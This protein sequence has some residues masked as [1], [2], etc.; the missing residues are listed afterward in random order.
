ML[1]VLNPESESNRARKILQGLPTPTPVLLSSQNGHTGLS[2]FHGLGK[3]ATPELSC[4]RLSVPW[5]KWESSHPYFQSRV[6]LT[7]VSILIKRDRPCKASS[8]LYSSLHPHRS[9][10]LL[11]WE[12]IRLWCRGL[13]SPMDVLAHALHTLPLL[14]V[15]PRAKRHSLS[16]RGAYIERRWM[17]KCRN[18][19]TGFLGLLHRMPKSLGAWIAEIN[20]LRAPEMTRVKLPGGRAMVW[21]CNVWTLDSQMG[22]L[23]CGDDGTLWNRLDIVPRRLT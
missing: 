21:V 4:P 18:C 23:I 6:M 7:C 5:W 16:P 13:L 19:G 22:V 17:V 9:Y 2:S 15:E 10:V 20:P 8:F 3:W 1:V 12:A 14:G 11:Y